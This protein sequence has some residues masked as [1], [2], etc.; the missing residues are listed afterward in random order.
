MPDQ[1]PTHNKLL[2]YLAQPVLDDAKVTAIKNLCDGSV[3]WDLLLNQVF[4]HG[5]TGLA[6]EF[7]ENHDLPGIQQKVHEEFLQ[8][9]FCLKGRTS[10]EFLSRST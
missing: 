7:L 2:M 9:T 3:N 4:A 8:A 1:N 6:G 10:Q 5:L